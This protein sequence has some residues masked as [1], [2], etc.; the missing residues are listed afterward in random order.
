MVEA[1]DDNELQEAVLNEFKEEFGVEEEE[2]LV[3]S[4]DASV[5]C[6]SEQEDDGVKVSFQDD[7]A[8]EDSAEKSITPLKLDEKTESNLKRKIKQARTAQ[9]TEKG[10]VFLGR[11]PHGMFLGY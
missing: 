11:I 3:L 7:S 8:D 9:D 1:S 5:S 4:D 6:E 2:E 10:V